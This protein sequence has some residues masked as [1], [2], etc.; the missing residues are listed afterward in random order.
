MRDAGYAKSYV[1]SY[2]G[3]LWRLPETQAEITKYQARAAVAADSKTKLSVELVLSRLEQAWEVA[4]DKRDV[5]GMAK[6]AEMQGNYLRMW[7]DAPQVN[8]DL[9]AALRTI[10]E[11]ERLILRA[12]IA[13]RLH[14]L[15]VNQPQ[16][17]DAPA[18]AA[19][20]PES[21]PT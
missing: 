1:H 21:T 16:I 7:S 18:P 8:A 5:S 14:A 12:A 13:E 19:A 9:A 15:A 2:S 11:N 6:V 17:I 3:K 10:S 4:H 20:L